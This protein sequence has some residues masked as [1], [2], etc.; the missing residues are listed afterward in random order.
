MQKVIYLFVL[1]LA[2]CGDK[3]HNFIDGNSTILAFG[4]SLTIG[5]GVKS[6]FAYPQ[7]LQ[8]ISGYNV[9]SSGVSGETSKGGLKRLTK[10]LK[11]PDKSK[12]I[13][14]MI[15]LEGGNDI[16]RSINAKQTKDNLDKM[17]KLAK[18]HNILVLLVGVPK[19]GFALNDAGFYQ[20]LANEN[21]ILFLP[22]ELTDLLGDN[23]YKSDLV[24][25]NK[26]GYETLAN[27]IYDYLIDNN[28]LR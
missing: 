1:L 2:S 15:L 26:L 7:V 4:D 8:K 9:L 11:N 20:E 5:K 22:D 19:R 16:L 23:K 14:L 24:H 27:K 21:E 3:A 18:K 25:L 12:N 28:V 17:I 10:L 13:E 6:E